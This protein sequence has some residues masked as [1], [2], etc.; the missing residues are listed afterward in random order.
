MFQEGKCITAVSRIGKR[1]I[2]T[3]A[4]AAK[5]EAR[6]FPTRISRLYSA[7]TSTKFNCIQNRVRRIQWAAIFVK[8]AFLVETGITDAPKT[9][10]PATMTSARIAL[11]ALKATNLA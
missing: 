6:K 11:P 4:L 7:V 8:K 9:E 2:T 10:K 5:L 3:F 1:A